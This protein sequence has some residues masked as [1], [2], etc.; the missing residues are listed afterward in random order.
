MVDHLLPDHRLFIK[1]D[2]ENEA[3]V[4]APETCILYNDQQV[5]N[6]VSTETVLTSIVDILNINL[7]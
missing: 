2:S 6:Q 3:N 7:L 5:A 1:M 4:R